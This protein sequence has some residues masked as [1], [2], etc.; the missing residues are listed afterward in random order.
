MVGTFYSI[1][2]SN[3]LTPVL[4]SSIYKKGLKVLIKNRINIAGFGAE[5]RRRGLLKMN[6]K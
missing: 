1:P 6:Q 2:D 3:I 5:F 4:Q